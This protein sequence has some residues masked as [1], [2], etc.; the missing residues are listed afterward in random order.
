L[1]FH[2]SRR[3]PSQIIA[4]ILDLCLKPQTKTRIMCKI[5]L[6]YRQLQTYLH[7]MQKTSLLKS[8]HSRQKYIT[9]EKGLRF[10]QKWIEI[11]QILTEGNESSFIRHTVF[12]N[13]LLTIELEA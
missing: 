13:R 12:D 2:N 5:N 10:L 3:D 4:E 6:S 9:T 7:K 8:H 1:T 11:Q